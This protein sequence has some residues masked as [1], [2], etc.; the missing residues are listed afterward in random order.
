MPLFFFSKV[1]VYENYV[2]LFL[3]KIFFKK[4]RVQKLYGGE[5]YEIKYGTSPYPV[6]QSEV[7]KS[8]YKYIYF[9]KSGRK[10]EK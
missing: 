3:A 2:D 9:S 5:N 1:R 6:S 4:K 8:L 7:C 10:I